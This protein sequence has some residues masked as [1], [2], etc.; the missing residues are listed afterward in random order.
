ML[1]QA[2][3]GVLLPTLAAAR[4]AHRAPGLLP[5]AN[6]AQGTTAAL[7]RPASH[8]SQCRSASAAIE[9]ACATA[10]AA[11]QRWCSALN[12]ASLALLLWSATGSLWVAAQALAAVP[13]G[14]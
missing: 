1:G 8:G 2:L 12:G 6:E 10:D 14:R 7:Q 13:A 5:A 11:L 9:R 3:V 4:M